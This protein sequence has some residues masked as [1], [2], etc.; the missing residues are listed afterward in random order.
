[1]ATVHE[2]LEIAGVL[3]VE[4]VVHGDERGMFVETFRRE[5]VP[6][7]REI[8]QMNRADREEGCVV[9]LHYHRFQADYWYVA[10][11]TARIVLHDLRLGSPTEGATQWLDRGTRPDG[12]H[13]HGGIYIPPGV[14]HGFSSLTKMTI[15]YLVDGYY[16]PADELGVAWDDPEIAADWGITGAPTL[17]AR[18]AANP[19]RAELAADMLPKH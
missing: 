10:F 8:L 2:S 4:P 6:Q 14:A 13:N 7:S 15:A 12:T 11:G 3:L 19:R 18:D 17:S 16:D 5:W 1:M 9:G